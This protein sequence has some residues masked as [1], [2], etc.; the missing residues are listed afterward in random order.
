MLTKEETNR[1]KSYHE[2]IESAKDTIAGIIADSWERTRQ[3]RTEKAK[4]LRD[5]QTAAINKYKA[6]LQQ[7][8]EKSGVFRLKRMLRLV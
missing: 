1:I 4:M 8:I 3:E 2:V 7:E 5:E 6:D